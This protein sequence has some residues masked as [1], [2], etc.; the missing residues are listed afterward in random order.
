MIRKTLYL[1]TQ[2]MQTVQLLARRQGKSKSRIIRELIARG[3][4]LGPHPA[5]NRMSMRT[6]D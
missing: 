5:E 3:L 2:Q 4:Q 6:T 1:T